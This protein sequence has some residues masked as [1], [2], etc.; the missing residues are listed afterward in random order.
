[1]DETPAQKGAGTDNPK[2][3]AC[4]AAG[5]GYAA[6]LWALSPTGWIS[7]LA[8]AAAFFLILLGLTAAGEIRRFP[9]KVKSTPETRRG[10]IGT[11]FLIWGVLMIAAS[12]LSVLPKCQARLDD[13][14]LIERQKRVP[15]PLL[16]YDFKCPDDTLWRGFTFMRK[17]PDDL[18]GRMERMRESEV[19]VTIW[20]AEQDRL[21]F[22]PLG[23]EWVPASPQEWRKG[24]FFKGYMDIGAGLIL[25]GVFMLAAAGTRFGLG[26]RREDDAA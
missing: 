26:P 2:P 24:G 18:R 11:A 20:T 22:F 25:A 17:A 3:L 7:P 1:M 8:A 19:T 5:A 14:T 23:D 16:I 4:I 9:G 10:F 12:F 21:V 6:V 13:Y 15:E